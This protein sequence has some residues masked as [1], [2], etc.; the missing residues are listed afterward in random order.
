MAIAT[1]VA[2][3]NSAVE[4]S[5][6]T[7]LWLELAKSSSWTDETQPDA[8]SDSTTS[9]DTPLVYSKINQIN[10]VYETD[11]T[12]SNNQNVIIYGG[13]YYLPA[14]SENAYVNNAHFVLFT[15]SI[16]VGAIPSFSWRQSGIVDDVVLTNGATGN[17]VTSDKVSSVGN[18][19]MY[20]NH[21]VNNYTDDMKLVISYLAEF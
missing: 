19:Y 13:K 14:T 11:N 21:V 5:K 17:I 10:I 12:N 3:V 15:T 16:D 20:D 7:N 2:H 4:F 9:L 18:L 8:E 1:K 6:R